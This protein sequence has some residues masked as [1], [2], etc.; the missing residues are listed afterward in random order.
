MSLNVLVLNPNSESGE[1]LKASL[2]QTLGEMVLW[3]EKDPRTAL[4]EMDQR[5]MELI[6]ADLETPGMDGE[7]FL[8]QL[9][10]ARDA[11]NQRVV[12]L[13]NRITPGLLVEY[14]KDPMV[15]FVQKPAA[16]GEIADLAGQLLNGDLSA[17]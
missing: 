17:S 14:K 16:P 2:A 12:A 4:R 1:A 9:R 13:S 5:D 3:E 6:I 15:W 7:K 8:H 11:A 10:N